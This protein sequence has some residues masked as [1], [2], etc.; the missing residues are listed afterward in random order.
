MKGET[1]AREWQPR[2]DVEMMREREADI[3]TRDTGSG[4][5]STFSCVSSNFV[6]MRSMLKSTVLFSFGKTLLHG[7]L[8]GIRDGHAGTRYGRRARIPAIY[9]D[10]VEDC[11]T[12]F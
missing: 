5:Y 7:R 3:G 8:T 9:V 11:C 12:Y 1:D 4:E 10:D 6:T 2:R